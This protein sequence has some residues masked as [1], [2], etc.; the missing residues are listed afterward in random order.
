[1]VVYVDDLLVKSKEPSQ[2]IADLREA[3]KVLC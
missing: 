2:H 1:M 3:F